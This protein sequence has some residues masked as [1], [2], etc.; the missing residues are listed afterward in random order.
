MYLLDNP[1]CLMLFAMKY[2]IT[3]ILFPCARLPSS[4]G[5]RGHD[6]QM[7]ESLD[8]RKVL[9]NLTAILHCAVRCAS[10]KRSLLANAN[11]E[12]AVAYYSVTP[13]ACTAH[14]SPRLVALPA[15]ADQAPIEAVSSRKSCPCYSKSRESPV[16]TCFS[17]S[18]TVL[19]DVS[20]ADPLVTL[21]K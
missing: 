13:Y 16:G 11:P 15:F 3:S 21:S 17:H 9:G 8:K 1:Q 20:R 5:A 19:P 12:K 10:P 6:S 2:L 7:T 18:K 4:V 14:P